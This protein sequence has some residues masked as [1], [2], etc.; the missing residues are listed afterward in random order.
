MRNLPF[1]ITLV[2]QLSVSAK[3]TIQALLKYAC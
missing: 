2:F 1:S 3:Y